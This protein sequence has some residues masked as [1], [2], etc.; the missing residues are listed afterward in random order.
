MDFLIMII[1][2]NLTA[3]EAKAQPKGEILNVFREIAR[4]SRLGYHFF[5][6]PRKL[7]DWAVCGLHLGDGEK[8][9]I[10][11]LG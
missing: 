3:E 1:K 9:H 5:I 6:I 8:A 11:R 7:A 4:A 2:L 10:Q